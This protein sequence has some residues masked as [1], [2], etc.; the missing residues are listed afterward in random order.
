MKEHVNPIIKFQASE[1]EM[2]LIVSTKRV[3][4]NKVAQTPMICDNQNYD[5][6]RDDAAKEVTL[7]QRSTGHQTHEKA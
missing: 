4:R 5:N 3:A 7:M 1:I 2:S 6:F